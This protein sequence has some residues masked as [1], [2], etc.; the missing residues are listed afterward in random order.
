MGCTRHQIECCID[1]WSCGTWIES[2]WSE[3][4]YKAIYRSHLNSL[5]D[6][7]NHGNH[8]QGGDLL[9]QIQLDLLKEAR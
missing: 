9:A 7:S 8:R 1:E 4:Y 3:E 2:T 6:L 5:L